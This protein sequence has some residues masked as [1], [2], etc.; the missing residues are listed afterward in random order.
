MPGAGTGRALLAGMAAMLLAAGAPASAPRPVP[1]PP[2]AT[3]EA[4]IAAALAA[5]MATSPRPTERPQA[6]GIETAVAL[7]LAGPLAG[8]GAPARSPRP[9]PRPDMRR[10]TATATG[11]Q[12]AP[13][14]GALCGRRQIRGETIATIPGR[15]AGCGIA[16][17]VRVS[18]VSGVRLNTPAIMNC[19][20]ARTLDDWVRQQAKPAVGRRGGGLAAL[21]VIASYSCRTRNSQPGARISEHGKGNAIDIAGITLKNGDYIGV[22]EDWGK[23]RNGRLLRALHEGACGPFGTV[24]GPEAD[25]FH[26]DHLHFDTASYRGGAYCR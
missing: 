5:T 25:R 9:A 13:A 20:T 23:G 3:I 6:Q 1:R 17:P 18:E 12:G 19:R 10:A 11:D 26:R 21:K 7:A 14:R 4:A 15:L 8:P 2:P 22:S 24:L 16:R